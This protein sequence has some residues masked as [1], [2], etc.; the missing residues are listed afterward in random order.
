MGLGKKQTN[1]KFFP[2]KKNKNLLKQ[3]KLTKKIG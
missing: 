3:R 1:K 2:G